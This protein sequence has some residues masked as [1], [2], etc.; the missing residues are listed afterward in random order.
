MSTEDAPQPGLPTEVTVPDAFNQI[1]DMIMND[2]K[3]KVRVIAKAENISHQCVLNILHEHYHTKK[4]FVRWVTRLLTVEQKLICVVTFQQ[5][6]GE[7]NCNPKDFCCVDLQP[8]TKLRSITTHWNNVKALMSCN[9]A[10]K[11]QYSVGKVMASVILGYTT[12][13]KGTM[14]TSAYYAS[15]LNRLMKEIR[16]TR[17]YFSLSFCRLQYAVYTLFPSYAKKPYLP[18]KGG[19]VT[20]IFLQIRI[21]NSKL[22]SILKFST[23]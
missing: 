11:T 13:E 16:L 22:K 20:S 8:W 4:L 19:C 1:H 21:S 17:L 2:P 10:T 15:A 9:K 7:C 5:Y 12:I 18:P 23:I 14:I 6:L 3:V